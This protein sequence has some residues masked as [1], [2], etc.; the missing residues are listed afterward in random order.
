M[1]QRICEDLSRNQQGLAHFINRQNQL[2]ATMECIAGQLASLSIEHKTR[3][4]STMS[5]D[6]SLLNHSADLLEEISRMKTRISSGLIR[7]I[8]EHSSC[9]IPSEYDDR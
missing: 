3:N 1:E 6:P 4:V 5:E 8:F 9:R 2:S 7:H